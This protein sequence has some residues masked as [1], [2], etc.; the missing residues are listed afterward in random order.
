[1]AVKVFDLNHDGNE[2]FVPFIR[3][4]IQQQ[5]FKEAAVSITKL[6]LQDHF[7]VNEVLIPLL[8]Q[9]KVNMLENYVIGR[10]ELQKQVVELLDGLCD[11]ESNIEE[12]ISQSGVEVVKRSNL[13]R[14]TLS[15]LAVR[16]MKLYQIPASLCPNISNARGY[17]ALKYLLYKRYIEGTMG[18]GSWEEMVQSA[19]GDSV[20]LKEQLLEQLM[21]YNDLKEAVKWAKSFELPD[22]SIPQPVLEARD[23]FEQQQ[24]T[25][26]WDSEIL[27]DKDMSVFYYQLSL[28]LDNITVVDDKHLLKICSE[29]LAIPDTVIGIDS[30]WKPS[31]GAETVGV[32]L[33][34]LAVQE[35]IFL[36]DMTTL[37]TILSKEEICSFM[38]LVFCN[39]DTIKLGYGFDADM[40]MLVKGFP[41]FKDILV[42]VQRFIDLA[43]TCN[44]ENFDG[45]PD[46][47]RSKTSFTKSE[48]K[49]L[50]ELVRQCF[51]KPLNK[52]EQMSNWERRPLRVEQLIYASLD[53]YVLLELYDHLQN[54]CKL[55][56]INIE[57]EPQTKVNFSKK[58]KQDK[59]KAK[60]AGL[61]LR[62]KKK[63]KE[64]REQKMAS[65]LHSKTDSNYVISPNELRVVCD[66]MLQGTGRYLRSCGVDVK[67][68]ENHEEHDQ[69]IKIG[70]TEG[71]IILSSGAPFQRIKSY[72]GE[73][74]CYNVLSMGAQEQATEVLKHFNVKV[75]QR[76]IFSRCQVCN[77]DQYAK[78][79]QKDMQEIARRRDEMCKSSFKNEREIDNH[80]MQKFLEEYGIDIQNLTFVHNNV[81]IQIDI[82]PRPMISK[83]DMFF[84]CTSCGKIFWEGSHF[85]RICDQFSHILSLSEGSDKNRSNIYQT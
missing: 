70:T 7:E 11:R 60:A 26:D 43:E 65:L 30:E 75:T 68:M 34:Q 47:A 67:I 22:S 81:T 61:T 72:V 1:M 25:D 29:R 79:A 27:S 19:V 23:K 3:Y 15:K 66:T 10:P 37:I 63:E 69:A 32:A 74:K 49:G 12:F 57:M 71:R 18:S 53:A 46:S 52:G 45:E 50:S 31:M 77:G 73:E 24:N 40:H 35:H 14:K 55:N 4:Y 58:S 80:L 54:H 85:S 83:V 56:D 28:P 20:Y 33:I 13:N 6:G 59:K 62:D 38:E 64:E 5:K 16:L 21:C 78:M 84:V 8:I 9:D 41:Y 76:D 48:E 51:G 42:N 2:Y 17:G 82:I 36:F 39:P 44:D